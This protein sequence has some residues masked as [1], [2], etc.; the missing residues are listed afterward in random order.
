MI[1][2][3]LSLRVRVHGCLRPLRTQCL[4]LHT[5]C[6]TLPLPLCRGSSSLSPTSLYHMSASRPRMFASSPPASLP[7]R[8]R[9]FSTSIRVPSATHPGPLRH[10]P[11]S[12]PSCI[13]VPS[14]DIPL[15]LVRVPF[16]DVWFPTRGSG[17]IACNLPLP[18][19]H[20]G[21]VGM[22]VQRRGVQRP[23]HPILSIGARAS[24]GPGKGPC[25]V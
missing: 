10:A 20:G 12:P 5:P 13:R 1:R 11:T 24:G 19:A 16:M 3:L 7:P 22:V 2:T 23:V 6:A 9:V 17:H 14:T 18:L 8:V 25:I 21:A 15:S 4:R